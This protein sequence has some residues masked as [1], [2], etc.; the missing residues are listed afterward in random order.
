MDN[1]LSSVKKSCLLM[2]TFLDS[3]PEMGVTE[4]SKRLGI[5]KGAVYKLLATLESEGFIR[6]NP[7]TKRYS[8][9]YTLL[10]LGHKVINSQNLVE[11]CTPDLTTLAAKTKE[12]VCLCLRDKYDAIYMQKI[13]SPHPIRFNVD[14][15]RRFPLY[16][17]SASRVI[18]AFQEEVFID[19]ILSDEL[20][21]YTERS[22]TDRQQMKERLATIRQQK[23]EISSDMRNIGVTGV[24]APIFDSLAEVHASISIIGP[25]DRMKPQ[26]EQ[27]IAAVRT[28]ATNISTSLG[29]SPLQKETLGG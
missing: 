9:G 15:Y 20:K 5:S 17:T 4:L 24:A 28:T 14:T 23:Y 19:R 29:Y 13:D 16:A 6:Q 26:L 1:Y 3:P 2:K 10:E 21:V 25:S 12:L 22:I 27:L 18:L 11:L 7:A 8:L